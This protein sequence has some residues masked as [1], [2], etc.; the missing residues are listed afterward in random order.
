[1]KNIFV[2]LSNTYPDSIFIENELKNFDDIENLFVFQNKMGEFKEIEKYNLLGIKNVKYFISEYDLES[3]NKLKKFFYRF[4]QIFQ[5]DF[6]KELINNRKNLFNGHFAN[7][8]LIL[9]SYLYNAKKHAKKIYEQLLSMGISREDRLVF[10]AFRMHLHLGSLYY[11]KEYFPNSK[12][13]SRGHGYDLFQYRW[14]YKYIPM[15]ARCLK[16][17]DLVLAISDHGKKYIIEEYKLDKEKVFLN[18]LGKEDH[19]LG[20]Y[21]KSSSLRL[22]SCSR[23]DPIKRLDRIISTLSL[24]KLS[25]EWTHIGGGKGLND[26]TSKAMKLP[27][28]VKTNF[29]GMKTNEEV[30]SLYKNM[31]FDLFINVSEEEGLPVSIMEAS[32][33]GIPSVATDVGGSS[34]IVNEKTGFLIEKDFSDLKLLQIIE[35]Y[36][37]LEDRK[38]MNYRNQA[39][40][41]FI[42]KFNSKENSKILSNKI[43]EL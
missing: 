23:M 2:I 40:E 28:N 10:Y 12:F 33:F 34:E 42:K 31:P 30:L 21:E 4:L 41:T 15:Q 18:Y 14:D 8:F 6:W 38:K 17:M 16:E 29:L 39:R 1:M 20:K 37:N 19:G 25:I 32:S 43:N 11:L 5:K 26:L 36:Y 13:I 7:N 3:K 24:S 27:D 22:V 9:T 35:S